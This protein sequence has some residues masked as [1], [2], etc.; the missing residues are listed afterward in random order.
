[1]WAENVKSNCRQVMTSF[2]QMNKTGQ[3]P[4]NLK[5]GGQENRQ[6]LWLSSSLK[7]CVSTNASF[8]LFMWFLSNENCAYDVIFFTN[9]TFDRFS[10]VVNQIFLWCKRQLKMQFN[11]VIA[12][13]FLFLAFYYVARCSKNQVFWFSYINL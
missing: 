9:Y 12:Q 6:I 8:F 2:A 10:I 3:P 5:Y 11:E 7:K 13:M 4:M 1:M